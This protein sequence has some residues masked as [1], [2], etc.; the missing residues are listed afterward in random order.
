MSRTLDARLRKLEQ[1]QPR[2]VG[3]WHRVVGRSE[4]EIATRQA[5]LMA[6][7]VWSEGDNIVQRMIISPV[8]QP[9]RLG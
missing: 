8:A 7:P 3:R 5:E 6:S 1:A 2:L 4:A 9:P